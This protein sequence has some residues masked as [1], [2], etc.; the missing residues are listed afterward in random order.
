[1]CVKGV[2][3]YL[4]DK[5]VLPYVLLGKNAPTADVLSTKREITNE[6][7][8]CEYTLKPSTA[9]GAEQKQGSLYLALPTGP[10]G[11]GCQIKIT[12]SKSGC[13][14][15]ARLVPR[16]ELTGVISKATSQVI[17]I[18]TSGLK[19]ETSVVL[20]GTPAGKYTLNEKLI[21]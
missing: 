6:E 21:V 17:H 2:A 11:Q 12:T 19:E 16:S 20:L 8:L 4:S 3:N 5:G 14:F 9:V 1:M 7:I 15:H 13:E 18:W 10:F